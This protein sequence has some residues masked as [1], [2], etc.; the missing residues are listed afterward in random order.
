MNTQSGSFPFEDIVRTGCI[1]ESPLEKSEHASPVGTR[2]TSLPRLL[3][4][5]NISRNGVFQGPHWKLVL[6]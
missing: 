6:A 1:P 5:K 4:A 3:R 2:N